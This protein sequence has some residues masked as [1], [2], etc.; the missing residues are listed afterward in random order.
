MTTS[1]P[2]MTGRNK[3]FLIAKYENRNHSLAS[4]DQLY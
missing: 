1:C 4:I 2:I 3:G